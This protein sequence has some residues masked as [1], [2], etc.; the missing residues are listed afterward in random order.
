[1]NDVCCPRVGVWGKVSKNDNP[2]MWMRI[3]EEARRYH[4]EERDFGGIARL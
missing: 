2:E 4:K 3:E 1:M